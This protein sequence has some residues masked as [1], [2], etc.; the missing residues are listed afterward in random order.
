MKL[1][2]LETHDRLQHFIKDQSESIYQGANDCLKKN[3]LSLALQEKAPYIYIWAHPRTN[4]DANKVM[5]WQPRL[6]KPEAQTNS[7][8][9]R[10]I[11]KTDLIEICWMIPPRE[12]WDAYLKGKV[13]ESN[14][15]L[16]SINQFK[17][18][19][20]ALEQPISDD[21]SE[22]SAANI[23]RQVIKEHIEKLRIKPKILEASNA[24]LRKPSLLQIPQ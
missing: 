6:S 9:F 7:Y 15:T 19:R 24:F 3:P 11:S 2:V 18:N 13:T 10:A 17:T 22:A 23:M 14:W 12:Q 4:D 5:F 16:W 1:N 20:K 8:L 21:L